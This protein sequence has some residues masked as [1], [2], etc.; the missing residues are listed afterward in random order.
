MAWI[1]PNGKR[2]DPGAGL[3]NITLLW[4]R[5]L[6]PFQNHINIRKKVQLKTKTRAS[7]IFVPKS[8]NRLSA[9]FPGWACALLFPLV[10]LWLTRFFLSLLLPPK[11]AHVIFASRI[12]VPKGRDSGNPTGSFL[13]EAGL[14]PPLPDVPRTWQR[15]RCHEQRLHPNPSHWF[16]QISCGWGALHFLGKH[17]EKIPFLGQVDWILCCAPWSDRQWNHLSD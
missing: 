1:T 12:T 9:A 11:C 2:W 6:L 5:C 8:P 3:W 15:K 17:W 14:S 10:K 7:G 13:V 16:F 4:F